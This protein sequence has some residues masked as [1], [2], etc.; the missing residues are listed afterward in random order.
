M[1][2]YSNAVGIA[3]TYPLCGVLIDHYGWSAAFYAPGVIG[4]LWCISWWLLVFDSP[5]THP[6]ITNEEKMYIEKAVSVSLSSKKVAIPWLKI[7]KSTPVWALVI[8]NLGSLWGF[9]TVLTYGPTY[10]KRIH[11]FNIQA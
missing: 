3:V 2:L 1:D 9:M 10:F 7:A 4:L 8:A 5:S 6:R 11:G